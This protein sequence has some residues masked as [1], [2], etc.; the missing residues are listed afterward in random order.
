MHGTN[1]EESSQL[2]GSLALYPSTRLMLRKSSTAGADPCYSFCASPVIARPTIRSILGLRFLDMVK[3]ASLRLNLLSH[4][5]YLCDISHSHLLK[6][7]AVFC[8]YPFAAASIQGSASVSF[9]S[10]ADLETLLI[11]QRAKYLLIVEYFMLVFFI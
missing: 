7:S 8:L 3:L 5:H 2:V 6:Q 4:P 11:L 9:R 1:Q 10:F